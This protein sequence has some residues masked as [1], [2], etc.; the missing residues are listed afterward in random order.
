MCL[1]HLAYLPVTPA[2]TCLLAHHTA[3]LPAATTPAHCAGTGRVTT[4]PALLCRP[5]T[6]L[7]PRA[8][9]CPP[10]CLLL[11]PAFAATACYLTPPTAV[12]TLNKPYACDVLRSALLPLGRRLTYIGVMTTHRLATHTYTHAC[13]LICCVTVDRIN[14]FRRYLR[15]PARAHGVD[16]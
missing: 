14:V 10:H 9:Y 2:C 4:L 15:L 1:R 13:R 16:G 12:A 7:H 8:A 11:T 6:C 5:S 3:A